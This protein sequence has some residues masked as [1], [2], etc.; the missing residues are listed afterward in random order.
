MAKGGVIDNRARTDITA[1]L[2][3]IYHLLASCSAKCET[4]LNSA[5]PR[6]ENDDDIGQEQ[7]LARRSKIQS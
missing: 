1:T 6:L 5:I 2:S 7:L 3:S 4:N